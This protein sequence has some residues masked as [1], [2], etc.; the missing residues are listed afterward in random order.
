MNKDENLKVLENNIEKMK[1]MN[2]AVRKREM[3]GF[4]NGYLS[5]LVNIEAVS[6]NSS[7]YIYYSKKIR[8]N[9]VVELK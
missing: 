1:R 2:N 5:A 9:Y 8:E 6:F 3:L 4:C 7:E